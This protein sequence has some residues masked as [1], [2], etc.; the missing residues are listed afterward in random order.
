MGELMRHSCRMQSPVSTCISCTATATQS[1]DVTSTLTMCNCSL[2]TSVLS[3]PLANFLIE[4]LGGRWPLVTQ[5]QSDGVPRCRRCALLPPVRPPLPH[6]Q[7]AGG[8]GPAERCSLGQRGGRHRRHVERGCLR[9]HSSR[10]VVA[11]AC[12]RAGRG[13]GRPRPW[14]RAAASAQSDVPRGSCQSRTCESS[15]RLA[16]LHRRGRRGCRWMLPSAPAASTRGRAPWPRVPRS[17]HGC[18][19][20]SRTRRTTTRHPQPAH[21]PTRSSQPWRSERHPCSRPSRR[22]C[23]T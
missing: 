16:A 5:W 7:P 2:V 13:R 3:I 21:S 12:R 17:R 20:A 9:L 19:H 18:G 1:I 14:R 10:H 8:A 15:S 4:F 6:H 23:C 22:R 11:L